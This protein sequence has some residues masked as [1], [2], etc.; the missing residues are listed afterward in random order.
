MLSGPLYIFQFFE[1][2]YRLQTSES[3]V[4]RRQILTYKDSERVDVINQSNFLIS[5]HPKF[6][7]IVTS[8]SRFCIKCIFFQT[9]TIGKMS[10]WSKNPHVAELFESVGDEKLICL[11]C[12]KLGQAMYLVVCQQQLFKLKEKKRASK[13]TEC[14]RRSNAIVFSESPSTLYLRTGLVED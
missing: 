4:Y 8:R 11:Q 6:I 7:Y 3:D 13:P 2:R 5:K 9:D 10:T 12:D 1:C 14:S